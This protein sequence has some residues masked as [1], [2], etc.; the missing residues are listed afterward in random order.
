MDIQLQSSVS[1]KEEVIC[2]DEPNLSQATSMKESEKTVSKIFKCSY[3]D[4]CFSKNGNL[5]RHEERQHKHECE[6]CKALLTSE[7]L[8]LEHLANVHTI[9]ISTCCE[10]CYKIFPSKKSLE[11]HIKKCHLIKCLQCDA[12]FNG[13]KA[14]NQHNSEIHN[15]AKIKCEICNQT[16][17]QKV[18]LERHM[19]HLHNQKCLYCDKNLK[20]KK[21]LIQHMAKKHSVEN[22]Y[23]CD[24]CSCTFTRKDNF[25]RHIVKL[26]TFKCT[27]CDQILSTEDALMEHWTNSHSISSCIKCYVCKE[28]FATQALLDSHIVLEHVFKCAHCQ[29]HFQTEKNLTRHLES[30][31]S[32][33]ERS[34]NSAKPVI[35][36]IC[37][38]LYSSIRGFLEHHRSYHAGLDYQ[39]QCTEC[40]LVFSTNR[41]LDNHS[42]IHR[43]TFKY[44]FIECHLC[45]SVFGAI[46][47]LKRHYK[48]ASSRR[49]QIRVQVH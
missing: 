2:E 9:T 10:M 23:K 46:N 49:T 11:R 33:K 31:H 5:Q 30:E 12:V 20:S 16:F 27:H 29:K 40:S 44:E 25:N 18:S 15:S 4:M 24:L 48:C 42:Q 3:C 8:M 45:K 36:G 28:I 41:R 37:G 7:D 19:N 47:A 13:R 35:C 17:T 14:L 26:H 38:I 6:L 22:G 39:F 34:A 1:I 21:I 43:Q 32:N